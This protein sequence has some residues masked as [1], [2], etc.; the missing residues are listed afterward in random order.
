MVSEPPAF[1]ICGSGLSSEIVWAIA[2][3][4]DVSNEIV[5]PAELEF[6]SI[7][8]CRKLP[9]PESCVLLTTM[10]A[11]NRRGSSASAMYLETM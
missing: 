11:S 8:A 4:P 3:T 2:K 7:N 9:A 1:E 5:S 10:L 6:A